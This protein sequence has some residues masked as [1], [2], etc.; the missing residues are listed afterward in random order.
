MAAQKKDLTGEYYLRGVMETGSGFKLEADSTFQFFF[1]YGALDREGKGTWTVK[2]ETV[3][4]NS[5]PR[6]GND[7]AL[8]GSKQ[9]KDDSIIIKIIDSSGFFLSH[10]YCMLQSGEKKAEGVSN[11]EGII[12]FPKQHINSLTLI[13]EFCPERTSIFTIN[14]PAHNYF[15]FRFEPWMMEV[16]FNDYSLQINGHDLEGPHP[17]LTG[18]SYQ[19]IKNR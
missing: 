1:S 9:T 12:K 3:V 4:F 15:E 10:V 14:D 2:N 6:P 16:F 18:K 5:A 7:F 19:F 8:S 17:L 11:K 13:F